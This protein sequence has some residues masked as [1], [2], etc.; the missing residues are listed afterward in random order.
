M[1]FDQ[2]T[3]KYLQILKNSHR[4]GGESA[5]SYKM[6]IEKVL[7]V[8]FFCFCFT[9]TSFNILFFSS[10]CTLGGV[11]LTLRHRLECKIKTADIVSVDSSDDMCPLSPSE[12]PL[13]FASLLSAP[14]KAP[15]KKQ[16]ELHKEMLVCG[17]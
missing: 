9:F 3:F 8:F 1:C 11:S 2:A 6:H 4:T 12:K 10:L 14:N 16:D 13:Q 17:I 5:E 15:W 7:K